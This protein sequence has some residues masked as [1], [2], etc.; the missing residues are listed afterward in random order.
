M[1][2]KEQELISKAK[3]L[4]Q[5]DALQV[6]IKNPEILDPLVYTLFA[7]VAGVDKILPH[8]K[9]CLLLKKKAIKTSNKKLIQMVQEFEGVI[10]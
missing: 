9:Y 10:K 1:F 2:E 6:M 5:K 7:I 8:D 3:T 4:G